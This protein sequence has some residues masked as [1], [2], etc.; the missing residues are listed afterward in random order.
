MATKND[1]FPS[2]YLKA[3][4]LDEPI[5]L[6][7][8]E[9]PLEELKY[10]ERAEKKVVMYF[11]QTNKVFPLNKVNWDSMEKITGKS[12]SDDWAGCK[13]ELYPTQT[14]MSGETVD[15]VRIRRPGEGQAESST[16]EPPPEM[17]DSIP[18]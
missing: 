7:V 14:E 8:S 16:P 4:D 1:V 11:K 12:D 15:C 17:G 18:F 13:V 5:V 2:R 10:Q 3:A 6:T 9:A